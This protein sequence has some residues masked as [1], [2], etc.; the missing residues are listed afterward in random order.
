M[1]GTT[2]YDLGAEW[3]FSVALLT[4]LNSKNCVEYSEVKEFSKIN[5]IRT[6][7]KQPQL[8]SHQIVSLSLSKVQKNRMKNMG[9]TTKEEMR[10]HL[11]RGHYKLR[12]S[13]LYWW[14][15]HIR[16]SEGVIDTREY[17][18]KS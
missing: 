17:R 1:E 14:S 9:M 8:L 11:V 4:L 12:K 15:S 10:A 5:K 2:R 18:V 16:G 13:G 6:K 7:K 3:R